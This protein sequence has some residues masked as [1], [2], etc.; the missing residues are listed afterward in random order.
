VA[1][2][3]VGLGISKSKGRSPKE[4]QNPKA[5]TA[6]PFAIIGANYPAGA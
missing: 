1:F 3:G 5:E 4:T 2:G 6:E